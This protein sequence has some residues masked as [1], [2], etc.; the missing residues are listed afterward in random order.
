M[1]IVKKQSNLIGWLPVFF[2][3]IVAIFCRLSFNFFQSTITGDGAY[4]LLQ[5]RSILE[6]GWLAFPDMPLYF[7][8]NAIIAKII[9]WLNIATPDN[10]IIVTIKLVDS[11]IPPLSALF[12]FLFA[13]KI[14]NSN[15]KIKYHDYMLTAFS[16]LFFPF[17]FFVSGE[18]QKNAIGIALIFLYLLSMYTFLN[19][20]KKRPFTLIAILIITAVTHF[21]SFTIML[22][23][24][25]LLSL[26]YYTINKK[27]LKPINTKTLWSAGIIVISILLTIFFLDIERA[28]RLLLLPFQIFENPTIAFWL[29]GQ[30]PFDSLTNL[31][32]LIVNLFCI[33]AFI[34]LTVH[35][36]SVDTIQKYFAYSLIVLGLIL[37]SPFINIQFA[38]R[39]HIFA[40]IP[41]PIVYLIIFKIQ[42]SKIT[43]VVFI[44][45]FSIMVLHS[46]RIGLVAHR[47]PPM[48]K[49]AYIELQTMKDSV[50]IKNNSVTVTRLFLGWWYAWE[51]KTKVSQDYALTR[52]D[53]KKY[54]AVYVL[55]QINVA[56][57]KGDS[58]IL[59]YEI[60]VPVNSR[61]VYK[62]NNFELYELDKN[63][64]WKEMPHKAPLIAGEVENISNNR[65][66]INDGTL[67][68]IIEYNP[69]L[70]NLKNGER[71]KIWEKGSF[72]VPML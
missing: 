21:G 66:T 59:D 57:T 54:S 22:L 4:Y 37:A 15:G 24:T 52:Q 27:P 8:F 12:V 65:F 38:F 31:Y 7:Y 47:K 43:R 20:D 46:L 42:I 6:H 62:G 36:K 53:F 33:V 10:A 70:N 41:L 9:I 3:L 50:C 32:I 39:L 30:Q 40:F 19:Q 71:V 44:A 60:E 61:L 25:M 34:I 45:L 72:L 23:F 56:K 55:R 14:N 2:I 68:Y 29:N 5:V 35:R 49:E 18:L 1:N 69:E 26:F 13:K 48:S 63:V 64:D 28:K 11:I 67:H 51:L 16:V 58:N 17:I